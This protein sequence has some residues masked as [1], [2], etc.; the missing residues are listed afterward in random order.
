MSYSFG[1]LQSLLSDML[2]TVPVANRPLNIH[3]QGVIVRMVGTLFFPITYV[4]YVYVILPY[5]D[6]IL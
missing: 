5:I 2:A 3:H 4:Q 1:L 6:L